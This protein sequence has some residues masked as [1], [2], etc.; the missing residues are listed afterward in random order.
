MASSAT[1]YGLLP[2]KLLGSR[3]NN[4]GLRQIPIASGYATSIFFGDVV[5]LGA[6]AGTIQKDVGTTTLTP[7]GVF[8][9][10]EYRD[11]TYG[12]VTFDQ[13]FKAGTVA[14]A[15]T[16]IWAL[17][18][19][20]PDMIFQIQASG[21]LNQNARGTNAAVV[22]NAGNASTGKSAVTLNAATIA[23]T[24]TLPLRIVDFVYSEQ[25]QPGDAFTDVLV[26][27]NTHAY[28]TALGGTP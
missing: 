11:P 18:C 22:Q 24:A 10:C 17:V 5:K 19:D 23:A 1:P 12:W 8:L 20:D 9:G 15:G 25:S 6:S 21:S 3:P 14:P 13:S 27:F 16:T 2:V 28:Y 4:G 7:I 26:R